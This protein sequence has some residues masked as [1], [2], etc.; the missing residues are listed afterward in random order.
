VYEPLIDLP[1]Q[2]PDALIADKAYDADAIRDDLK[3]RGIKPVIPPKSNRTKTIR[4]AKVG[5]VD[6]SGN[7]MTDADKLVEVG[8]GLVTDGARGTIRVTQKCQNGVPVK[9]AVGRGEDIDPIDRAVRPIDFPD[10][11]VGQRQRGA[12]GVCRGH[13][14]GL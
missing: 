1:E 7:R 13:G 6:A 2:A 4:Y 10:S 9:L 14:S 8:G 11:V 3:R 5:R 12:R